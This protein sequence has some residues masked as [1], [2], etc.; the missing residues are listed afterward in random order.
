MTIVSQYQRLEAVGQLRE[1]GSTSPKRVIVQ[2]GQNSLVIL[3]TDNMP[4]AHWKLDAVK[5]VN[6]GESPAVYSPD[7]GE[8][9]LAIADESMINALDYVQTTM[10]SSTRKSRLRMRLVYALLVLAALA[11]AAVY[12]P[13]FLVDQAVATAQNALRKE[14]GESLY[15][16]ISAE[17]GPACTRKEG[18]VAL[19][20]L[21]RKLYGNFED[22][23]RIVRDASFDVLPLPGDIIVLNGMMISNLPEADSL[24]ARIN[25]VRESA[26]QLSP[27]HDILEMAGIRAAAEFLFFK[28]MDEELLRSLALEIAREPDGTLSALANDVQ[29]AES[30]SAADAAGTSPELDENDDEEYDVIS[31]EPVLQDSLF[32]ALQFI[33]IGS[34]ADS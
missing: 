8:D 1:S 5:R 22:R 20:E 33:C 26:R 28:R 27:L 16:H 30:D 9:Q 15:F 23:L 25:A 7:G 3:K 13:G 18:R 29:S 14:I 2:L 12:G 21:E 17:K 24:A 19:K 32:V 6:P 11:G 4:I 10:V 31:R 34:E